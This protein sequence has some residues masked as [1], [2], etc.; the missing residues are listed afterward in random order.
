MRVGLIG[1]GRIGRLHGQVLASL[2]DVDAVVVSDV[3]A[4]AAETLAAQIRGT[5]VTSAADAITN[6]DAMGKTAD[7]KIS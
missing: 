4:A 3:N 5:A 7:P 6:V 1:A 2:S